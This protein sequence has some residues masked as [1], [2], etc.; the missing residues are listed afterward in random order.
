VKGKRAQNSKYYLAALVALAT[1]IVYLN[2]LQN[3]FAGVWDDNAYIVENVAIRSLDPAFFRWAFLDFY[4]SN[5]HPLTW[6][7]HAVDYA[8]WGLN[9]MGHH[10]TSIILHAI[11][12]FL[13]VLLAT[14]LLESRANGLNGLNGLNKRTLI[15]AGVAG[16]LFGLHPVHVESV[17]WVSER[18]DLLCAFFFLL[19]IMAYVKYAGSRQSLVG[20][21]QSKNEAKDETG[22]KNFLTNKQYILSLGFFV[23]ALMSKPM[24]VTLPFV[25]LLLDWHPFGRIRSVK[26]LWSAA[27]EKLPFFALSLASSVLTILAQRGGDAVSSLDAVPLSI[28]LLVA[29]KALIA[30]LGKM[31]LPLNLSPFYPY[32]REVSLFSVEYMS[33]IILV[34]GI[35]TACLVLAAKQKAWLSAWGYYVVTLLPVLGIVQVG[36]Q[37]MADRYTYLPSLGP[38]LVL[39]CAAAWTSEKALAVKKGAALTKA[40]GAAS[41]VILV[42]LLSFLAIRQTA[43]WRNSIGLWTHVIDKA[44]EK[45]PLIYVNR[46]AAFQLSG[47]L[48][49]AMADFNRAI[50][51]DPSAYRAY[52]AL[53]TVLEQRGQFDQAIAVVDRAIAMNPGYPEAYRNRGVLHDKMGQYDRAIADYTKAISLKPSFYEA[54][55]SRGLAFAK[56]GRFDLAIAD[57]DATIGINPRHI[58]VFQNRG[59]AYTLIGSYDRALEDFN[60]A[61]RLDRNDATAYFNRGSFHR[62]LGNADRALADLR[63]ACALGSEKA[64]SVL[65]P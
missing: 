18:K 61:I 17:A 14:R 55:N 11:N 22:W 19:S 28:R 32:P 7:S 21:Q 40:S 1:V 54:F 6:L 59:I 12:T 33:A 10:L 36:S 50:D 43:V 2:A 39:G 51:V 48:D 15:A 26:T 5:W 57:Y 41:A 20:S 45:V 44:S 35:T 27:V 3:E 62:R 58:G 24:A 60:T 25:L 34:I 65:R 13:V 53:G 47:L 4:A 9:P 49:D 31:L 46:G 30:Y 29:A 16:L 56:T 8:F 38:F 64:C 63:Q 23:L 42:V 52:V 37:A